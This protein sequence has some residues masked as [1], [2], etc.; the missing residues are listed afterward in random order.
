MARVGTGRNAAR[1]PAAQFRHASLRGGCDA[2]RIFR[3]VPEQAEAE[4]GGWRSTDIHGQLA[5]NRLPDDGRLHVQAYGFFYASTLA[6]LREDLRGNRSGLVVVEVG[7]P[8]HAPT[9]QL[10]LDRRSLYLRAFRAAGQATWWGFLAEGCPASLPG[11]PVRAIRGSSNYSELGLPDGIDLTA[12][13]LLTRLASFAG[14][15]GPDMAQALVLLLFLVP[16]ALRFDNVLLP[17]L[18]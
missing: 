13:R 10:V 14:T 3:I 16:E 4:G 2:G 1:E 12:V 7:S 18:A 15:I 6:R 17:H 5:L 8:I 9:L 11:G